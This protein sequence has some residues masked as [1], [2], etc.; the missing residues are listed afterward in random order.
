MSAF[1]GKADTTDGT[2]KSQKPKAQA[3][4]RQFIAYRSIGSLKYMH[5]FGLDCFSTAGEH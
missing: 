5:H 4:L 2:A 3:A 1:G